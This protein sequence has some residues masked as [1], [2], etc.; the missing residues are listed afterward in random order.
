MEGSMRNPATSETN[1][2]ISSFPKEGESNDEGN[3]KDMEA[4]R[5]ELEFAHALYNSVVV[6]HDESDRLRNDLNALHVHKDMLQSKFQLLDDH[7][8]R[9]ITQLVAKDAL[10]KNTPEE[11]DMYKRRAERLHFELDRLKAEMQSFTGHG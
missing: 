11:R 6:L 8:F 1:S 5:T 3:G 9:L 7:I 4:K 10:L 2:S